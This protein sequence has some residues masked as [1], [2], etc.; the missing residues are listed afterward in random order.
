MLTLISRTTALLARNNPRGASFAVDPFAAPINGAVLDAAVLNGSV[1][2]GGNGHGFR[3]LL[4]GLLGARPSPSPHPI[5]SDELTVAQVRALTWLTRNMDRAAERRH[6]VQSRRRRSDADIF[7]RFPLHLVPTYSGDDVL[8]HSPGF[9]SWL[10]DTP[11]LVFRTLD[12][13][14]ARA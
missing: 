10:P 7:A 3:H 2:D 12:E 14:M 4:A 6:Q 13:I 8:F 9:R 11:A 5:V 1:R